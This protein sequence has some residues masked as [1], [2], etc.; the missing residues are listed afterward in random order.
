MRNRTSH[1]AWAG[2]RA[3]L[4]AAAVAALAATLAAGAQPALPPATYTE[5]QAMRGVV[6]YTIYCAGC[7]G[8]M[9]EGG[10]GP[11][12]ISPTFRMTWFEAPASR[13]FESTLVSMPAD[14]PGTL[15]PATYADIIAHLLR[16]NG[17]APGTT[18]LP[19]TLTALSTVRLTLGAAP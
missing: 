6:P 13:L 7:H 10:R 11:S 5:A 4:G 2:R 1:V 3:R 18:P 19:A 12:L 15:A 16:L 8:T 17:V 14:N 9:A